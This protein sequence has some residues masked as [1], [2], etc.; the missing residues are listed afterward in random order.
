M[1]IAKH[2]TR[3]IRLTTDIGLTVQ[4]DGVYNVFVTVSS[5]YKGKTLGLCGTLNDKTNDDFLKSD[6]Q[7]TTNA[8]EF[9]ISWKVD[10]FCIDSG[11]AT[12]PC[13]KA[14][15]VAIQAKKKCS[16]MKALPFSACNRQVRVDSGF[17]QDC[18]F[19]VCACNKDPLACLCEEIDAYVTTC[20]YVGIN[21]K[22]KHLAQFRQCGELS[23]YYAQWRSQTDNLVVKNAMTYNYSL[24]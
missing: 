18:E 24:L 20:S 8:Q 23:I 5:R 22:W 1:K 6:N 10:K 7:V 13:K 3:S 15:D 11:P 21:I 17:L 19:D 9:G 14:G 16:V 12:D 4:Y 2:A